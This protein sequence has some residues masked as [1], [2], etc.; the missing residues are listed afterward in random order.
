MTHWPK[1]LQL[2]SLSETQEFFSELQLHPTRNLTSLTMRMK[3]PGAAC[4][5][6]CAFVVPLAWP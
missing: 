1:K 2:A 3:L 4:A 5:F 6:Y